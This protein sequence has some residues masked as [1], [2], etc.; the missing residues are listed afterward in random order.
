MQSERPHTRL[1][2]PKGRRIIVLISG[3]FA[4]LGALIHL[5]SAMLRVDTFLWSPKLLDFG[6]YYVGAWS[7]RMGISPYENAGGLVRQLRLTEGLSVLP[8]F[9][10]SPP[11]WLALMEPFTWV[12]FPVAA[13]LWVLILLTVILLSV[14]SLREI[15]GRGQAVGFWVAFPLVLTFGP[16]FL[17]LTL[18]QNALFLLSAILYAGR[19]LKPIQGFP[20][21]PGVAMLFMA[22]AAKLFPALWLGVLFV[23][24]KRK[25]CIITL[26]LVIAAMGAAALRNP[27][28]HRDYWKRFL[29]QRSISLSSDVGLDDQSL[30]ACVDRLSRPHTF[31]VPGLSVSR[32]Q[33]VTWSLPW[34]FTGD[35]IRYTAFI[36]E[37][38]VAAALFRLFLRRGRRDPEGFFYLAVLFFLVVTPHTERYN[39]VAALPAMAWLWSR[40]G[41]RYGA[42]LPAYLLFGLSRLNHLWAIAL[43][44]PLAALASGFGLYAVILLGVGIAVELWRRHAGAPQ[45]TVQPEAFP[46]RLVSH[47]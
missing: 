29:P 32:T 10:I 38:L 33:R 6:S 35:S 20:G 23:L 40:D 26:L 44:G 4:G 15:T 43:P 31:Q 41:M 45:A 7:F 1:E 37:A 36:I 13:W 30:V 9:P 2:L 5:G 42:V 47:Q 27:A 34:A 8:D 11:L 18:G 17:N 39:H 12:S 3:V 21:L 46:V 19:M 16:V 14:R 28:A 22:I 24:R 25:Y